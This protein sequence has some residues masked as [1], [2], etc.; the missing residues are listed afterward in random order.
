MDVDGEPA[1]PGAVRVPAERQLVRDLPV[2]LART[3]T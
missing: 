1:S 2:A 3:R